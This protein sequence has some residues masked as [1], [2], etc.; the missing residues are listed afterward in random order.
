[1]APRNCEINGQCFEIYLKIQDIRKQLRENY[2]KMYDYRYQMRIKEYK[3]RTICITIWR[4]ENIDFRLY[5]NK[6]FSKL[7][8]TRQMGKCIREKIY[9]LKIQ[10]SELIDE[11]Q[12]LYRELIEFEKEY[13]IGN[14]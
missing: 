13:D 11:R 6:M 12:K 10:I 1:M 8:L 2:L 4:M 3:L 7:F 14:L 9:F 5:T